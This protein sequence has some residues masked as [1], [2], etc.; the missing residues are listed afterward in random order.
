M[1]NYKLVITTEAD[2]D[3]ENLYLEGFTKWGETQADEY[4][5]AVI[6]HF[7]VLCENPYLYRAV[8]EIRE[9]YR[10]SICGKHSVYYRIVGKS[11]EIMAL[12]KYQNRP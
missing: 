6:E 4:Y 12:V 11:V 9:G 1:S 10:R 3:L 8:N 2:R 7:D 5:K